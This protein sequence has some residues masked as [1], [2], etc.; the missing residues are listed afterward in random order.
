MQFFSVDVVFYE[1][2]RVVK[3]LCYSFSIWFRSNT[4]QFLFNG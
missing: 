3:F 4:E 1:K 2:K